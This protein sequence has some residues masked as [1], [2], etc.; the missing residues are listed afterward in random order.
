MPMNEELKEVSAMRRKANSLHVLIEEAK[1]RGSEA[2]VK[3]YKTE[4]D[5]LIR[6]LG[7]HQKRLAKEK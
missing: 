2:E 5:A 3:R 4:Y 1:K 7:I 6:S